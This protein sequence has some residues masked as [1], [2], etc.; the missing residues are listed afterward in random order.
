MNINTVNNQVN[1]Q[2]TS[3]KVSS[4]VQSKQQKA[5]QV[6]NQAYSVSISAQASQLAQSMQSNTAHAVT[7]N[8]NN[9]SAPVV[10]S[11]VKTLSSG[12]KL[13]LSHIVQQALQAYQ[14]AKGHGQSPVTQTPTQT[15]TPGVGVTASITTPASP[16]STVQPPTNG[17]SAPVGQPVST[18]VPTTAKPQ[19]ALPA[20]PTTVTAGGSLNT[21]GGASVSISTTLPAS[22]LSGTQPVATPFN[23]LQTLLSTTQKDSAK[24]DG[25]SRNLLLRFQQPEVQNRSS[26][27]FLENLVVN[28]KFADSVLQ[29][30]MK[31]DPMISL[32][33]KSRPSILQVPQQNNQQNGIISLLQKTNQNHSVSSLFP[34]SNPSLLNLGTQGKQTENKD[35]IPKEVLHDEKLTQ[36]MIKEVQ[37]EM[38]TAFQMVVSQQQLEE[39]KM[40]LAKP[41]LEPPKQ[42]LDLKKAS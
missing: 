20:T 27:R 41:Q 2:I 28:R 26:A 22:T 31:E 42:I 13:N 35:F 36:S 7:N 16:T 24:T 3:Q 23:K 4:V 5:N 10:S 17:V 9:P 6:V 1:Q 29:S 39:Q 33:M 38:K 37:K 32:M 40:L 12:G 18:S 25:N 15:Q 34:K 30:Q 21:S 11:V 19:P 14:K 8:V